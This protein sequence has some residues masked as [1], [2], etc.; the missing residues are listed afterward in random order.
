AGEI[1]RLLSSFADQL[2]LLRA[3]HLVDGGQGG[4]DRQL[5]AQRDRLDGGP[6]S[7][8]VRQVVQRLVGGVREDET[9]AALDDGDRSLPIGGEAGGC[10]EA[11]RLAAARCSA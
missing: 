4:L 3:D 9:I 2:C 5:A 10:A 1:R 6:R 8:R 11:E 7:V